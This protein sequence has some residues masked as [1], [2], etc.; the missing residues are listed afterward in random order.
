MRSYWPPSHSAMS[1]TC[2][3]C[4]PVNHDTSLEDYFGSP[5][6]DADTDRLLW[7][8]AVASLTD[9][10]VMKIAHNANFERTC[11]AAA[12]GLEM[13][14]ENWHCTMVQAAQLG[15]PASLE[16]LGKAL[17]LR[18]ED[19]KLTA[20]RALIRTFCQPCTPTARNGQRTRT[21]P[22]HEPGKWD[23]FKQYCAQDVET[24]RKCHQLMANNST[25]TERA[26]WCLDQR[27]NDRGVLVDLPFVEAASSCDQAYRS[28]LEKEALELTGLDNPKSVS[29]LKGWLEKEEGITVDSLNKQ[30]V[31]ELIKASSNGNT[32]RVLEIRQELSKTSTMK[33][34]AMLR[35]AGS[36]GRLRGLFQFYGAATG[37]WAGRLVQSRI[38]RRTRLRIST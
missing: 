18:E 27:I 25:S 8:K 33:Y 2:N 30:N 37:R 36:D 20:G 10:K 11:L 24:E 22:H 14:P 13:P 17:G 3:R 6:T 28:R 34:E 16:Q 23:L 12:F 5:G 26:L 31:P 15:L 19:Q 9:P 1:C 32:Q 38:S 21:L 4:V 29:Q 35:S 7:E